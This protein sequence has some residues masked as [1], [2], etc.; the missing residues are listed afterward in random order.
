MILTHSGCPMTPPLEGA[1]YVRLWVF[2]EVVMEPEPIVVD[3]SNVE[4]P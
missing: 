2:H 4:L 1:V 3:A